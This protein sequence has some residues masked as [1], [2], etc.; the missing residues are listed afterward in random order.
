MTFRNGQWTNRPDPM[1][2]HSCEMPSKDY[3]LYTVLTCAW[4]QYIPW[5][6][7][8]AFIGFALLFWGIAYEAG[9]R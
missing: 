2:D 8:A 7:V 1:Y 5:K 3:P 9:C 6:Y 4:W